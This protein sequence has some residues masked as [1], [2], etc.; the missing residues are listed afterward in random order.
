MSVRD[1]VHVPLTE[2]W[3]RGRKMGF[4]EYWVIIDFINCDGE[5]FRNLFL[6]FSYWS[7]EYEKMA[8]KYAQAQEIVAGFTTDFGSYVDLRSIEDL[9]S[10]CCPPQAV[11]FFLL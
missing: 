11:E 4:F 1:L 2:W 6:G 7:G 5:V 8:R 3:H 9:E 10:E